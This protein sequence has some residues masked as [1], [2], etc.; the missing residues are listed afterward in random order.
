MSL[1]SLRTLWSRFISPLYAR[2][3]GLQ[4]AALC[5]RDG[6]NGKEVLL[7][8]SSRGRWIIPKG[9]PIAGKSPAEAAQQEAW[10]EAGVKKGFVSR[11]AMG[12]FITEKRFDDGTVMPC[13]MRVFSVAVSKMKNKFPEAGKRKRVWVSPHRAAQMVDD[14]DLKD[15]ISRL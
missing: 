5:H 12:S 6:K 13:E 8:S 9:W 1:F 14:D 4:L 11:T 3:Q 10:E 2:P 7:I 15:L